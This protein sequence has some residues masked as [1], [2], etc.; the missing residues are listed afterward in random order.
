MGGGNKIPKWG[1]WG[2]SRGLSDPLSSFLASPVLG[3]GRRQCLEHH[4]AW[5]SNGVSK[6]GR[7]WSNYGNTFIWQFYSTLS[8]VSN[9]P[10]TAS[11]AQRS[12]K[13][14]SGGDTVVIVCQVVEVSVTDSDGKRLISR[15]G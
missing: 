8:H 6:I 15:F 12:M 1:V 3:S 4:H 7:N 2:T 11:I 5:W 14:C 10:T 13:W 9:L